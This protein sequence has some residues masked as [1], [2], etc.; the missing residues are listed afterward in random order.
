MNMICF[1]AVMNHKIR[2]T[3]QLRR[4]FRIEMHMPAKQQQLLRMFFGKIKEVKERK[5]LRNRWLAAN[6]I[7]KYFIET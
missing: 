5:S 4:I 3:Q 1:Y 2:M 6:D 7:Q